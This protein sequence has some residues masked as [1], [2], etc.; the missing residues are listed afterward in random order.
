[1]DLIHRGHFILTW[2]ARCR[3][4]AVFLIAMAPENVGDVIDYCWIN[5]ECIYMINGYDPCPRIRIIGIDYIYDAFF[6]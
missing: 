5:S 2:F 4:G 6:N 3:C 1:M